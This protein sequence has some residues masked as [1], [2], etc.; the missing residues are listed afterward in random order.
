[1]KIVVVSPRFPWPAFTGDRLRA[2]IWLSALENHA[3]ATLVSP[4]GDVPADAPRFHFCPAAPSLRGG[5]A[6]AMRVLRGAPVQSLLAAAY[7]WRGALERAGSFDSAI[8]LLSRLDPS[9]RPFLPSGLRVLDAVDSLQRSMDE[10]ARA[11]APLMRWLWR[12]ESRRVARAEAGAARFYDRTLV[13]SEE[14]ADELGAIVVS[15]GVAVAPL[16]EAPRPFDFAFWGRLAYFANADAADWLLDEIWP[17]IRARRPHATLLIAGADA[18]ARFR[19]AHGHHGI[20]VRSPVED[21]AAMARQVKVALFPVRYGSGQ[22]CKALEA[23][24][25][26]CAIVATSKAMRG[27]EPLARHASLADDTA[28]LVRAA[29]A[30]APD[31]ALRRVVET[32]Y[33]RGATLDRLAAIV[34]GREAAA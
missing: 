25:A 32:T 19:A 16:I 2:T 31:G 6:G 28:G 22:S 21:V 4:P 29:L 26:G 11:S 33:G 27:L 3:S 30:A 20:V 10:R 5:V 17:A 15:N 8:V 12:E 14:E 9:V 24:E 23:A 13:V 1:V 7:D 34:C 18:P